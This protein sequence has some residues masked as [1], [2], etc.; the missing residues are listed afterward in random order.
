MALSAEEQL[1]AEQAIP[2]VEI[3]L[4]GKVRTLSCTM[5]VLLKYQQETGENPFQIDSSKLS[6]KQMVAFLWAAVHQD[7]PDVTLEDVSKWMSGAHLN[8]VMQIITK[9]FK[10]SSPKADPSEEP[11]TED[12]SKKN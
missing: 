11:P 4:G 1:A 3:H 12:S 7:E 5:Y 9:L 10:I 2:Q 8:K 6:P